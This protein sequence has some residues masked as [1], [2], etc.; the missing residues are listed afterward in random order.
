VAAAFDGGA[1]VDANGQLT[2]PSYLIQSA[3]F[4]NVGGALAALDTQT[5]SNTANINNTGTK[6]YQANSTGPA[7]S[8]TGTNALAMGSS[9]VSSGAN[10]IAIGTGSQATVWLNRDRPELRFDRY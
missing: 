4:N 1:G 7:A 10:A 6:Y 5:T 8:A 3:T 9:A 2:A